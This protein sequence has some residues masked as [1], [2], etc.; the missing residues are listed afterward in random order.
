MSRAG[1]IVLPASDIA[2]LAQCEIDTFRARG[3]GGQHV[4]KTDSAVRLTHRPTGIV[5][6]SQRERSQHLNKRACIQKLRTRVAQ[7]N[8]RPP[9]RVKTRMPKGV[10][11]KILQSKARQARKKRLRA[12]PGPLD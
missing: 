5:V 2:L 6:G 12:R 3:K 7:L 8:Y 9:K 10:R 1:K 11:E 4:N